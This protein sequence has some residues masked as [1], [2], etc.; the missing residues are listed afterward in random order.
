MKK[1]T[2]K[3][4]LPDAEVKYSVEGDLAGASG[5]RENCVVVLTEEKIM[6]CDRTNKEVLEKME[7]EEI[8]G[9][10]TYSKQN[11]AILEGY[12]KYLCFRTRYPAGFEGLLEVF[13]ECYQKFAV[14][15]HDSITYHAIRK[16]IGSNAYHALHHIAPPAAHLPPQR[17][18]PPAGFIYSDCKVT[19]CHDTPSPHSSLETAAIDAGL[20]LVTISG[21]GRS[22]VAD[23]HIP[24]GTVIWRE[25]PLVVW[26]AGSEMEAAKEIFLDPPVAEL[27]GILQTHTTQPIVVP[28]PPNPDIQPPPQWFKWW[29]EVL[30]INAWG[31]TAFEEEHRALFLLGSFLN[32]SCEPNVRYDTKDGREEAGFVALRDI[33]P[34]EELVVSY[35]HH[36]STAM[37]YE[38]MKHDRRFTCKCPR[39]ADTDWARGRRC[40][41]CPHGVTYPT[42][43]E[44]EA[45]KC[46]AC[47]SLTAP[48]KGDEK[49]ITLL[50]ETHID[51]EDIPESHLVADVLFAIQ[52]LG[53]K[54]WTVMALSEHLLAIPERGTIPSTGYTYLARIVL[55]WALQVYPSLLLTRPNV[56][57]ALSNGI[58][59][60]QASDSSTFVIISIAKHLYPVLKTFKGEKD[61]DTMGMK[62]VSELYPTAS[63][64]LLGFAWESCMGTAEDGS[65]KAL[66]GESDEVREAVLKRIELL[67]SS[68]KE[69]VDAYE[70]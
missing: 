46:T 54:H 18:E 30:Q 1:G 52:V 35:S 50:V 16:K 31:F 32:H 20:R 66:T 64:E 47:R 4:E 58:A 24:Q 12:D 13:S 57:Q 6:L 65:M 11:C 45:W 34:A 41:D 21:K 67:H 55:N 22:L 60:L 3:W 29:S 5:L 49:W 37:R 43:T 36:L 68:M 7:M 53:P 27:V 10:D 28:N 38:E 59:K 63:D 69:R 2:V 39:C 25:A 26:Q 15:K 42:G 8:V 70:M 51:L 56:T 33:H 19:S 9:V 17:P 23:E 40:T 61:N 48:D 44:D 14:R 62:A